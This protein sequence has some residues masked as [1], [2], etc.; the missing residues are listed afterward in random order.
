MQKD[1]LKKRYGCGVC[2]SE[3]YTV[4][5]VSTH[6]S[7]KHAPCFENLRFEKRVKL[8]QDYML[9]P[10]KHTHGNKVKRYY[11]ITP[12]ARALLKQLE[13]GGHTEEHIQ[14]IRLML[15]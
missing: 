11:S 6:L 8:A 9:P 7:E 4:G 13:E 12:E 3:Y 1:M 10:V 15:C 5:A 2:G 14:N